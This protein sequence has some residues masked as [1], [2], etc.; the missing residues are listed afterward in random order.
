MTTTAGA[1]PHDTRPILRRILANAGMLLGGRSVNAVLTLACLALAARALGAQTFGLLVL[2]NAFAQFLGE[3][4]K[5][6]SWQT[7]LHYGARPLAENRPADF[8][9]VLRFT[10]TLDAIGGLIGVAIGVAGALVFGRILGWPSELAPAAALYALTVAVM[11]TATPTG[12]LRL[13]DRFDIIAGQSS[14]VSSVRLIGAAAGFLL[15][16]PL[17]AFLAAWAAGT[18]AGFLYMGGAALGQLRRRRLAE[19]FRWRGPLTA[20][21]PGAWRFALATNF[22]ATLEVAFTH[23]V[24]LVL[25]ALL[26]PSQAAFWRVGRE[27]ADAIAKPARLLIPALYPELAKLRVEK[28]EAQMTRLALQ[29]GLVGGGVGLV[30]LA[31]TAAAGGPLLTLVLGEAFAPAARLMTWQVTAAVIAILALP[32]EPMLVSLGRPGAALRVRLVVSLAFLAAIGPIVSTFGAAGAGAALVGAA[33]AMAA[34]MLWMFLRGRSS[35][36]S[37]EESACAPPPSA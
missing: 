24:T 12:L 10:L 35:P 14:V 17:K 7:V 11:A 25:G 6:Q 3:V 27:V 2:I 26:G 21:M 18:V 9:Q 37:S 4:V 1:S 23:V 33:A 13:L 29:V 19:G 5:F 31:V 32:L 34:G 8:Q 15:H 20:G 28:G 36:E 16:W 30:L 22:S